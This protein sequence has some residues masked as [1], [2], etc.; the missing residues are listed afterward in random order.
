MPSACV[1]VLPAA[2]LEGDRASPED[3]AELQY[4]RLEGYV[5]MRSNL[6]KLH[7]STP[8]Q[9]APC[10]AS[11]ALAASGAHVYTLAAL[12]AVA[13]LGERCVR[14]AEARG[15]NP[16][17]SNPTDPDS[18]PDDPRVPRGVD[19]VLM[20]DGRLRDGPALNAAQRAAVDS[21]ADRILILAG[22]GTGKTRTLTHRVAR[23]IAH[24]VEPDRI[25]LATFTNRAAKEMQARVDL[26]LGHRVHPVRAGTFHALAYRMLAQQA[27][28]AGREPSAIIGREEQVD[29]LKA[30]IQERAP[31]GP[32]RLPSARDIIAIESY[33]ANTRSSV[34]EA[35]QRRFP[36]HVPLFDA[37]EDILQGYAESKRA[38]RVVDFDDLLLRWRDALAGGG[39]TASRAGVDAAHVLVDEYQDTSA[40]Q[41]EVADLLTARGAHLC[42]VGDDAQSIFA[43]RGARFDNILD[44]PRV[45][46]TEVHTLVENYRSDPSLLA[47][48]N[49]VIEANPLQ[50]PKK[51][52]ATRNHRVQPVVIAARSPE[53]EASFVAQRTLELLDKGCA[54]GDQAVLYRAHAH[55]TELE[56]E[57]VR[58]NI[59]YVLRSGVRTLE[60][61]HVRDALAF[62]RVRANR[63]DALA[64]QRLT[65]MLAGVGVEGLK[66]LVDHVGRRTGALSE[67]LGDLSRST[68]L[69]PRS[70][71]SV[72]RM[73]RLFARLERAPR[74]ADQIRTLLLDDGERI[75]LDHLDHRYPDPS[76][77]VEDLAR[78][79][80][81][82]VSYSDPASFLADLTLVDDMSRADPAVDPADRT[83]PPDDRLVLSTV[84]Q[85][86]GLEWAAVFVIHL[87]ERGFPNARAELEA[88]GLAEERRLFYVAITRAK[89]ELYLSH[90]VSKRVSDREAI[91]LRRSR[92]LSELD[93]SLFERWALT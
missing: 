54:L 62:V 13:Q 41:A 18:T 71:R 23:L 92:F 80:A 56:L 2:G 59:P 42:V 16:L 91:A 6:G 83:H 48:A 31:G 9:G 57:L 78:L 61:A 7:R 4:Q 85:A 35:V 50:F 47:V 43:F 81:A 5:K 52:V 10:G 38:A 15:S 19:G 73:G 40:L 88:D 36:D 37:I 49:A 68:V 74:P 89:D 8:G 84:H 51:L 64:W 90:P 27:R 17:S 33:A 34:A 1:A 82:A 69:A 24:G 86:K 11:F 26:L 39:E 30:V 60:Q 29:L 28:E 76:A 63:R 21:R 93:P 53:E 72:E 67:S 32:R 14:N 66:K 22:A 55:A 12:G 3:M 58:R 70:R 25:L 65:T 87:V 46:P 79:A 44:F 20:A 75:F 77:R 45:R